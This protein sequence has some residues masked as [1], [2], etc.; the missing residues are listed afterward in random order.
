MMT[1]YKVLV[2]NT[3]L[4]QQLLPDQAKLD[5][6]WWQSIRHYELAIEIP[7]SKLSQSL[8]VISSILSPALECSTWHHHHQAEYSEF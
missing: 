8:K 4:L 7:R 3:E 5:P 1:G 2:Q 6:G